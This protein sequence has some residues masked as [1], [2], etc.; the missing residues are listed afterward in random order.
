[1]AKYNLVKDIYVY[2][3][4]GEPDPRDAPSGYGFTND[5]RIPA[6]GEEYL[7]LDRKSVNKREGQPVA[8]PRL[9]LKKVQRPTFPAT[10]KYVCNRV[11]V[12]GDYYLNENHVIRAFGEKSDY[13]DNCDIYEPQ[14]S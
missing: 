2:E 4:Y 7:A 14:F 6:D 3:V 9:I 1:M 10:F 13:H 8:G 5:F 12:K 11:P